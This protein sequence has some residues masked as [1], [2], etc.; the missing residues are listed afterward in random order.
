MKTCA[1]LLCL[2][3]FFLLLSGPATAASD[4]SIDLTVARGD[5]LINI[6]KKYLDD[7][8]KWR[9]VA[10][11]NQLRNPDR[12]FP[13]QT[14]RIPVDLL[15]AV[16]ADAA[17]T[18]LRGDVK[19]QPGGSDRFGPLNL[20]DRV[21]QGSRIR[22]G[23]DGTVELTFDDGSTFFQ[24]PNTDLGITTAEQKG[25]IQ[26]TNKVL[27]ETGK[28]VTK[29]RSATGKE[30]RFEVQTPSSTGVARG[31]EFRTSVDREGATRVEVLEGVVAVS[32]AKT[33]IAVKEGEGTTVR[34]G[35]APAPATK[36]LPPPPITNFQPL[37][38]KLP[39]DLQ[40]AASEG[41][42]SY[43]F[44]VATDESFREVWEEGTVRAGQ[45]GQITS[46]REGSYF[47]QT[48]SVDAKGLEGP[49]S[50]PRPFR[51][52]LNPAPAFVR[53]PVDKGE[54]RG[55]TIPLS[56]LKVED[57]ASYEV[58]VASDPE[59]TRIVEDR[60][61]ITGVNHTFRAPALGTYY[62]QVRSVAADGYEG[63][64]T[65]AAEFTVAPTPAFQIEMP[66]KGTDDITVRWPDLGKGYSY[67]VQV[68]K[69]RDF[70]ET[71]VDRKTEKPETTFARPK[72]PG[73]YHVRTNTVDK[74]GYEGDF[75]AP[76]SFEVKSEF[77]FGVLGAIGLAIMTILLAL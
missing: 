60:K 61:G 43:R 10:R 74:T 20:K 26:F 66:G 69:N 46:L 68:A 63:A 24:R 70:T 35:E 5:Y 45:K 11:F 47:L 39:I 33:E 73:T 28:V 9:Q 16:P 67:R 52:R 13:G 51:L 72:E 22:T 71:L 32:G 18:F 49:S 15:K 3:G 57:A 21:R 77:S 64:W 56:W 1:V 40:F 65:D 12:I 41:V 14:I 4:K 31:T 27:V 30:S 19:V 53:T 6:C 59:F 36:L 25:N 55:T 62:F 34:S 38:K 7:P 54:Y 48:M 17:V 2:M 37:Y 42:A 58:R 44:A 8:E 75:S 50:R 76:Q 23:D 29:I